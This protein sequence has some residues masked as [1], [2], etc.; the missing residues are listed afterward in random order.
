[1]SNPIVTTGTQNLVDTVAANDSFA[2]FGKA[3]AAAGLTETLSG[4]GPFTVFAPTDDAF[5]KLPEGRLDALMLP[6]NKVELASILSYH[7]VNGHRLVA[8]IGKWNNAKTRNGQNAA[9]TMVDKQMTIGGANVTTCDIA[10]SNGVIH[11]I[12]KVNL[13]TKQ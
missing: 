12:D 11:G 4:P 6:E 7:V 3:I 10:T 13:P 2:T 5:A 8:D 9:I 1:M